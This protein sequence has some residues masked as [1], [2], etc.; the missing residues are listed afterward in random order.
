MNHAAAAFQ[1]GSGEVRLTP[2]ATASVPARSVPGEVR[3][4]PDAT[5]TDRAPQ[6][7][8]CGVRLQADQ[9]RSG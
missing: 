6:P 9:P 1:A 2:D 7:N 5:E 8:P 4:T 3:L